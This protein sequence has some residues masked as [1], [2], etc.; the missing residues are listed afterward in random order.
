ML[1]PFLTVKGLLGS[2]GWLLSGIC[3][4]LPEHT[5]FLAGRQL[6]L[7]ARC[8]GMYLA[9]LLGL[10]L[11]AHRERRAALLPPLWV[12]FFMAIAAAG[13]AIDGANSYLQ[14]VLGAPLL[15][16]PS[17]AGRLATGAL[18]G[19]SISMIIH[20]MFNLTLWS[21]PQQRRAVADAKDLG[22]LVTC[23]ALVCALLMQHWDWLYYPALVSII[24]SVAAVL[25]VLNSMIALIVLRRENQT[26]HPR[27]ALGPLLAG[28]LLSIGEIG[29]IALVRQWA[30]GAF[31]WVP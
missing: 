29:G 18:M 3:H 22:L 1:S 23:G 19:L 24:I 28:F 21:E 6:P 30:A 13:W 5:I 9:A 2:V 14:F 11:Q 16:A 26:Q 7:C 20:P 8:T 25:I 10:V 17:N 12:L 27:Q 4:Q 31:P 15:Y